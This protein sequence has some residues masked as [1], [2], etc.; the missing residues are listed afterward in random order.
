MS[1]LLSSLL[2][3]R[4]C[5]LEEQRIHRAAA[6]RKGVSGWAREAGVGEVLFGSIKEQP[7][8]NG[9]WLAEAR[10]A[11]VGDGTAPPQSYR[12]ICTR[13][14]GVLRAFSQTEWISAQ[15]EMR[16]Q[17]ADEAR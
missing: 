4:A 3:L 12:W 17:F 5:S 11:R 6:I 13:E 9:S 8:K 7:L 15:D 2:L 14:G 1:L 10:V 16:Y